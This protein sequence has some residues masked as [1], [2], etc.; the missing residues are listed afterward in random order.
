MV[1]KNMKLTKLSTLVLAAV[2]INTLC[3]GKATDRRMTNGYLVI[4]SKTAKHLIDGLNL[5][6]M[7]QALHDTFR[8]GFNFSQTV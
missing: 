1:S 5:V 6:V 3:V 7:D 4:Y 8:F 2:A